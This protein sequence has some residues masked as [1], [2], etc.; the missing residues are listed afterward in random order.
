MGLEKHIVVQNG[1]DC[2]PI[3]EEGVGGYVGSALGLPPEHARLLLL[4]A[5]FLSV[6]T[7]GRAIVRALG[8]LLVS[9]VVT[10]WAGM[11]RT[12]RAVGLTLTWSRAAAL[13][14]ATASSSS[15]DV[16]RY[17]LLE[18]APMRSFL[19]AEGLL[20]CLVMEAFFRVDE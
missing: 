6:W 15:A 2:T 3:G 14:D 10:T 1:N 12:R 7:H 19:S 11:R 5:A 16:V 4:A 17:E 18:P 9:F 8:I 13:Q 20:C